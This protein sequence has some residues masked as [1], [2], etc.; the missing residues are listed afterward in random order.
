MKWLHVLF[1]ID[2]VRRGFSISFG[3]FERMISNK[4]FPGLFKFFLGLVFFWHIY[5]PLHELL[6]VAGCFLA[7]GEVSALTLKPRYGGSILAHFFSFVVPESEYAGRLTG[8]TTP[9]AW[10]YALVDF[11]PYSLS[12]FGI[13]LVKACDKIKSAFFLGAAFILVFVPFMSI[14]GDYYEAVSLI[15]TKVAKASN[16]AL[17]AKALV[18]DDVFRSISQ[19]RDSGNLDGIVGLLVLAGIMA[20]VYLAFMTLA[21]QVWISDLMRGSNN[22][23]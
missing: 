23:P 8:F 9:G 4:G 5:V 2:T 12:L 22:D 13:A 3:S 10:G 18:S 19:L 17:D 14:P 16:L 7:G 11:L 21:L 6:H 15:T 1:P 20:A